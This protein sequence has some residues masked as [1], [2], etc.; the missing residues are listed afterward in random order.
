MAKGDSIFQKCAAAR[1][2]GEVSEKTVLILQYFF[3]FNRHGGSSDQSSTQ[4]ISLVD[5]Q[6]PFLFFIFIHDLHILFEIK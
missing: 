6:L 3:L 2:F 5:Q 1:N 4:C